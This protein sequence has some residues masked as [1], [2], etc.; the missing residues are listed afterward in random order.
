M[1][2]ELEEIGTA[3]ELFTIAGSSEQMSIFTFQDPDGRFTEWLIQ[4]GASI[5]ETWQA[6][7]SEFHVLVKATTGDQYSQF[8]LENAEFELASPA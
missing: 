1:N 7:P 5:P 4:K 3:P 6:P 2:P 8:P